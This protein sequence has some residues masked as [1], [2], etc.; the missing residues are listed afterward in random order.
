MK[1]VPDGRGRTATVQR[2][3]LVKSCL[4]VAIFGKLKKVAV[5]TILLIE[6][7]IEADMVWKKVTKRLAILWEGLTDW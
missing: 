1:S 7:K 2:M 6:L 3:N 4:I 5:M